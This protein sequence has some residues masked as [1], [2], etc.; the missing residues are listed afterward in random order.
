MKVTVKLAATVKPTRPI[1]TLELANAV[2]NY[3]G[4][5]CEIVID[6]NNTVRDLANAVDGAM[7]IAS[8]SVFEEVIMENN[9]P[10]DMSATLKAAGVDDGDSIV[11]RFVIKI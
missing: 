11:Y 7:G 6:N 2:R 9:M 5:S 1:T 8:E 3:V 10:L 4:K